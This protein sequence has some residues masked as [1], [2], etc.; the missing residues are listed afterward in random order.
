MVRGERAH[1][2]DPRAVERLGFRAP[3]RPR[4]AGT[5]S[6]RAARRSARHAARLPRPAARRC[7]GSRR[8][9][10]WSAS[11]R[12]RPSDLHARGPPAGRSGASCAGGAP[13]GVCLALLP[14]A[15]GEH[16]T[17]PAQRTAR[18]A[19]L[20]AVEDEQ[21]GG[22]R[23][24]LGGHERHEL[25]LDLDRVVALRDAQAVRD[26]QDVRVDGDALRDVVR[27]AQHDV[28][29][30]AADAGELHERGQLAWDF[31]AVLVGEGA[32]AAHQALRLR[33]EEAGRADDA[34]QLRR[35]RHPRALR[36]SDSA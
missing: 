5:R 22:A 8:R 13:V 29:G 33:A 31:A 10:R 24:A 19:D 3:A 9:P 14:P 15:Q 11:A 16:G 25:L 27:V 34:L 17:L 6:S 30:L 1:A 32:R 28:R 18:V 26:P 7:P 4:Y 36:A 35:A 20:A 23:P 21:V 2:R 12:L